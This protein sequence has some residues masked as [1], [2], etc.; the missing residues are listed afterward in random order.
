MHAPFDQHHKT[1]TLTLTINIDQFSCETHVKAHALISFRLNY[2]N[3][4]LYGLPKGQI[5]RIQ[6]IQTITALTV[7]KCR[8][9]DHIM[10]PLKALH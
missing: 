5:D 1:A 6:A 9:Y 8:K 4:L 2:S 10:P 3:S 7:V